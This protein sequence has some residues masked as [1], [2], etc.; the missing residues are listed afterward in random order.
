MPNGLQGVQHGIAKALRTGTIPLQEVVGHAL[1]RLR[2][3]AG[4]ATQGFDQSL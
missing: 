1:G 2:P 3:N 4:K